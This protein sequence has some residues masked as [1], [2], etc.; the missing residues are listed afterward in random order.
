MKRHRSPSLTPV[1]ALPPVPGQWLGLGER[2]SALLQL[3]VSPV[4]RPRP[5]A[6]PAPRAEEER[7]QQESAEQQGPPEEVGGVE[8][9][10]VGAPAGEDRPLLPLLLSLTPATEAVGPDTRYYAQVRNIQQRRPISV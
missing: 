9:E 10:V 6:G 7:P 8:G 1:C 5:R 2:V 3:L 4:A